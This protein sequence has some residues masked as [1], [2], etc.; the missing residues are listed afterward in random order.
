MTP[1]S[2]SS[3][4]CLSFLQLPDNDAISDL[5]DA[6]KTY[7]YKP[8]EIAILSEEGTTYGAQ[9]MIPAFPELLLLNFPREISRLRNAYGAQVRQ[10]ATAATTAGQIQL[11]L[12]WQDS[13]DNSGD[14]TPSYGGAQTP[15]SEDAVLT[16][17]AVAIQRQGIKV[18][19]I[20]ATDPWDVAF[21]IRSFRQSSPDVRLFVRDPDLL[22]LRL[23]DAGSL[24]GILTISNYPL[25]QQNQLWTTGR[26][27]RPHGHIT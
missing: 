6:L 4:D 23:S 25:I 15:F 20:L 14:S 21:L 11:E 7:G 18:L 27:G 12:D 17:L 5:V 9:G 13:H 26:F 22:F 16:S 3:D 8:R 10:P 19:G 2:D 1:A 24:N